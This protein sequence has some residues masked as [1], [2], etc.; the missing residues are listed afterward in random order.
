MDYVIRDP[1]IS[2]VMSEN[3]KHWNITTHERPELMR[4]CRNE[5]LKKGKGVFCC[6][7]CSIHLDIAD[8]DEDDLDV[9]YEPKFCPNCGAKVMER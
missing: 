8:M 9:F 5:S 3:G 6:S 1:F 2:C 4:M 7:S